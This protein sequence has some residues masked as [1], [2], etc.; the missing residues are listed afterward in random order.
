MN[1][2][3]DTLDKEMRDKEMRDKAAQDTPVRTL[4]ATPAKPDS[5]A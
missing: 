5:A 2:M 1:N 3:P 4:P